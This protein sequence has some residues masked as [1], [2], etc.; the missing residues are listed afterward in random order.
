MIQ[1]IQ[2]LEEYRLKNRISQEDLAEKLD[3][4]FSTVN[5]W[6]NG[7][8]KPNKIQEYHIKKLLLKNYLILKKQWLRNEPGITRT[9]EINL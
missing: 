8:S 7:K 6:L 3:V 4:A 2:E 5:R 9:A 1:L